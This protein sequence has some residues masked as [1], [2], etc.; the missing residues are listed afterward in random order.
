MIYDLTFAKDSLDNTHEL[1]K[2]YEFKRYSKLGVIADGSNHGAKSEYEY[3]NTKRVLHSPPLYK[4]IKEIA[5]VCNTWPHTLVHYILQLQEGDFLGEQDN[6]KTHGGDYYPIGK[7]FSVALTDNNFLTIENK[8][9][10]IPQ[11]HAIEFDP[12]KIHNI[13]KVKDKQT[14]LV[15]M[16]S[17]ST[18]ISEKIINRSNGNVL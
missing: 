16:I 12:A 18:N 15:F 6:I 11:Y 10:E 13:N 9:Y 1:L 7:F 14:W 4:S 3:I 5:L 2:S 8:L 17:K